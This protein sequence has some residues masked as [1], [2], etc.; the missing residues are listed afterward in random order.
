MDAAGFHAARRFAATP[1]GRVAYIERGSGPAALFLHGFP[2]NGFQWRGVIERL[3]P[4]RRCLAPD[5]LGLG[6]SETSPEQDL[7]PQ[8]QTE[9]IV[10]LLDA[11]A[12]DA[13]DIVAND[14]GDTVA[15]LLAA[16]TPAR[17]RSLLLTNGDVHENSPPPGLRPV[18]EAARAGVLAAEFLAPQ[19]ADPALARSATGLGGLAFTDPANLTDEAIT[20]YFAPLVSSPHRIDQFHRYTVAFEPNPL[21]PIE[22]H[23]TR[24]GAPMR[25]V[26]GTNDPLFAV[27]WAT[28]LDRTLPESRGIHWVE[29]ANLFFPEEM[30]D[31]IA[32]EAQ[33]LWCVT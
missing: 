6:Y 3:A 23:L 20:T 19:L 25:V 33:G 15:Q 26:W 14:S 10:S 31:L 7:A 12:I 9:M 2:L 24:S 16:H 5:F 18:I 8:A 21:P 22:A 1:F 27:D 30:P 28:W 11:L 4:H 17:V 29:G 32:A 13:V